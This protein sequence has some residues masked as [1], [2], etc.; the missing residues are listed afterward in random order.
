MEDFQ[1]LLES[2]EQ[3]TQGAEGEILKGTVLKIAADVV[4]VDVGRKS[5]GIVPL[6]ELT[7]PEGQLTV[8]PGDVID[9]VV[10]R[11]EPERGVLLS[12]ERAVRL[13]LWDDLEL[14][15]QQNTIVQGH[16]VSR[17]KGGL[18]CD[19]GIKAF[20]PGSQLE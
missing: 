4:V 1:T 3:Q 15:H 5:E 11:E 8:R 13:R 18:A 10:E 17:I 16:V 2:Y 14:A 7:N 9:V 19:I 12:H 6:R 20:L